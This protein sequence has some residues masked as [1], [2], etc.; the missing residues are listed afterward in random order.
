MNKFFAFLLSIVIFFAVTLGSAYLLTVID[1]SSLPPKL[2]DAIEY[3]A[4]LLIGEMDAEVM[5]NEGC[6]LPEEE[7]GVYDVDFTKAT[8]KDVTDLSFYLD[9]CPTEGK[10]SLLVIPVDFSDKTAKSQGYEI[11]TIVKAFVGTSEEVDY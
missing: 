2:H 7:D 3:L 11:D 8:F 4:G 1:S 6:G 5:S 10:S 9:G